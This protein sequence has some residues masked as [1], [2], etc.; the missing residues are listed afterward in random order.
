MKK[1]KFGLMKYEYRGDYNVGDYIQ[2]LAAKQYLPSVD[3]YIC[4]EQLSEY[5]GVPVSMI[6][7][8]WYMHNPTNFPPSEQIDPLFISFHLNSHAKDAFL[9]DKTKAYLRQVGPIGCRDFHTERVLKEA[10][11]DCYHS[12]CLT[13]TL[14]LVYKNEERTENIYFADPLFNL[15]D[16]KDLTKSLRTFVK[17]ALKGALPAVGKR[18]VLLQQLFD[19]QVLDKAIYVPHIYSRSHSNEE[20]FKLAE[21]ILHKYATAKF[22]V[23]SR[24]H[25]ALPCLALGTPVVFLNYGNFDPTDLCRFEGII[26][27]FNT[28]NINQSGHI[29]SNFDFDVTSKIGIDFNLKNPEK[30]LLYSDKLKSACQEFIKNK[31]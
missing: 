2:S 18:N 3:E 4:R 14:D 22:V 7:N 26:D 24:I 21:D 29:S 1:T 13:T 15:K 20:R 16:L 19:K 27:L 9:T 28:I 10:G 23:T 25:A 8:G 30:Y 5:S 6:M 17:G 31:I 11:I 12:G